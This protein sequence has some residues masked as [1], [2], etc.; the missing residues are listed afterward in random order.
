MSGPDRGGEQSSREVW[1]EPTPGS[2]PSPGPGPAVHPV[3][4]FRARRVHSMAAGNGP[5]R[6]AFAT[7]GDRIAATG[8]A[9]A[10]ADRFPEAE[11]VDLGDGV[12][13]PGFHDAHMHPSMT[14]EDLLHLDLSAER[15]RSPEQLRAALAE[16]AAKV[17]PGGWVRGSRYDHVKTS[18]GTP[19][20]RH[21]LDRATGDRPALVV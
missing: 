7:V 9:D 11:R 1:R 18:G 4:I 15:V 5:D 2:E 19:L 13:V 6:R 14:A 8:T 3:R 10:L 20:D 21:E 17:P 12:V 16:Q